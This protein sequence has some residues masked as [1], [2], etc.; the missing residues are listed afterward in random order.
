MAENFRIRFVKETF[1][2]FER[3]VIENI[4]FSDYDVRGMSLLSMSWCS[5]PLRFIIFIN[6]L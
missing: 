4:F 3:E 1:D 5:A 6:F 2:I